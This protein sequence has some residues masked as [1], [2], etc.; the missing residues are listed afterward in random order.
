MFIDII[1]LLIFLGKFKLRVGL[2]EVEYNDLFNFELYD[3]YVY[4][5]IIL[6]IGKRIMYFIEEDYFC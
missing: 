4:F 3:L 1:L 2:I 5:F 6:I